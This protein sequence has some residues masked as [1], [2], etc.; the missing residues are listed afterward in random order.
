MDIQE[1]FEFLMAL[2]EVFLE[3]ELQKDREGKRVSNL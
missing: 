2:D 1:Y 3:K